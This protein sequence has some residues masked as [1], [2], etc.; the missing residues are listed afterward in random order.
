MKHKFT[1]HNVLLFNVQ[2]CIQ[3]LNCTHIIDETSDLYLNKKILLQV[4]ITIWFISKE[5][6]Y[7]RQ[8]EK[9]F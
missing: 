4:R 3:F 6:A 9:I 7:F 8:Y 2:R 1:N 5:F